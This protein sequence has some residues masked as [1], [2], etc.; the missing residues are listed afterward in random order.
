MPQVKS[1]ARGRTSGIPKPIPM[2]LWGTAAAAC[3]LGLVLAAGPPPARLLYDGFVPLPPYRWVHPPPG[4]AGDNQPPK[5]AVEKIPIGPQGTRAAEVATEDD[6]I[7]VTFPEGVVA[8]R[9]G[10]TFVQVTITP[11]DPATIAPAPAG[12]PFDGNA[13]R[14]EASYGGTAAVPAVFVA[15]LTVVLRYATHATHALRN[16]DRGWVS[17]HSTRFEGSQEV[18]ANTDRLGVFVAAAGVPNVRGRRSPPA[19]DGPD[20]RVRVQESYNEGR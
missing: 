18:L 20:M 2:L 16:Q 10:E 9:P 17:L 7:F 14:I 4:R 15:P 12:R 19:G 3:Y 11:L 6:Q 13:Y 8:P 1:H 5:P